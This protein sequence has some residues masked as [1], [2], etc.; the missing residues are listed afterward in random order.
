MRCSSSGRCACSILC[1]RGCRRGG[2]LGLSGRP[3]ACRAVYACD[4]RNDLCVRRAVSL[5]RA[6]LPQRGVTLFEE[7]RRLV[8]AWL[9]LAT[10]WFAFLFLS[11]TGTD[12]SRVWSIYWIIA[13]FLVHLAVRGAIRV[14]LRMLRR[15][16]YNVRRIAIVGAGEFGREIAQ[17][18]GRM[19]WSGLHVRGFYDDEPRLHGAAARRAVSRSRGSV[20]SRPRRRFHRPG[21]D[22][23]AATG[24][25]ADPR[26]ARATLRASFGPGSLRAGHL[27]FRTCSIIR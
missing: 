19:P 7:V 13:G 8:N 4:H 16:G 14:T 10:A 15:R 22:R 23:P 12:F 24:G 1:C 26:S 9:L 11:K 6:L 27:Q 21:L 2:L 25:G 3:D 18:I 5:R 17:R 20:A